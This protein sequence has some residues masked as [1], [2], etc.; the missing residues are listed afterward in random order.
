MKDIALAAATPPSGLKG[1]A[2]ALRTEPIKDMIVRNDAY[3]MGNNKEFAGM[4]SAMYS[5]I[6]S[7][8]DG[9]YGTITAEGNKTRTH[10]YLRTK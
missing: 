5:F 7:Q 10:I 2:F 1:A 8:I 9:L 6:A 3:L 4:L